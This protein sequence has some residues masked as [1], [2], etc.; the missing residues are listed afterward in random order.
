MIATWSSSLHKISSAAARG[1]YFVC[2]FNSQM[3]IYR[4]RLHSSDSIPLRTDAP[5]AASQMDVAGLYN[6]IVG[7]NWIFYSFKSNKSPI[8][9]QVKKKIDMFG[10]NLKPGYGS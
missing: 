3:Y 8:C 1:I 10:R 4:E 5:P 7:G 2:P 6:Q 9:M